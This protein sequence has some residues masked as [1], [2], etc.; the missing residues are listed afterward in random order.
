MDLRVAQ[1]HW[2]C[3][4]SGFGHAC[5]KVVR[6]HLIGCDL[7]AM[8]YHS[9]CNVASLSACPTRL[10]LSRMP[11]SAR[12]VPFD[13]AWDGFF[14][15]YLYVSCACCQDLAVL[16]FHGAERNRPDYLAV[17]AEHGS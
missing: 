16:Q 3:H 8:P 1:G 17:L 12:C 4:W 10:H 5:R 13:V 7:R 2:C 11:N 14:S 9:F 15:F 6:V